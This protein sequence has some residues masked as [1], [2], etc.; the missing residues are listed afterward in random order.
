MTQV[1]EATKAIISVATH[2]D[3]INIEV[4]AHGYAVGDLLRI[5]WNNQIIIEEEM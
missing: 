2:T 5:S 4:T 1:N 3:G